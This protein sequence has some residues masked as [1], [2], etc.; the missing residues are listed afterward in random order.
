MLD[1][2]SNRVSRLSTGSGRAEDYR[3]FLAR[4]ERA[5]NRALACA[6]LW[7]TLGCANAAELYGRVVGVPDGDSI[8]VLDE[9]RR[10]HRVRLAGIDAPENGQRFSNRSRDHLNALL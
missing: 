6:C 1:R 10:Q 2:S 8:V 5:V 4:S 7:L 9:R 3:V